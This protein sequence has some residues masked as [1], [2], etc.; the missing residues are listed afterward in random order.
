MSGGP[1]VLLV[2]VA[3][4]VVGGGVALAAGDVP[5]WP[6]IVVIVATA[7][8]LVVFRPWSRRWGA[9]RDEIGRVLPGDEVVAHPGVEM[10]RAVTIDAPVDAVWPWLAQ[11]GQDRAAFYSY[12]WLENLAGCRLRNADRIHPE[13]QHREIGET[14]LLHPVAGIK[15]ARFEPN[16]S[17]AFEGGW[18]F[19]LTSMPGGRTRLLARSRVPRGL[20]SLGYAVFVELPHFIMERKMLLGIKQRAAG[21]PAS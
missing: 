8:Y 11:I 6:T 14:V 18:Y 12:D 1:I 15:L 19:A 20:P 17:Y 13:W 7:S 4:S 10:T 21:A 3:A 2:L 9:T 16:S 5:P